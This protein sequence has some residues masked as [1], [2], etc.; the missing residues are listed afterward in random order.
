MLTLLERLRM[1]ARMTRDDLAAKSGIPVRTI[2]ALERDG[3]RSPRLE[4][5]VPLADALSGPGAVVAPSELASDFA[6]IERN[7]A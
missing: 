6:A 1:D 2:R 4:T 7:A 3:I 5:L